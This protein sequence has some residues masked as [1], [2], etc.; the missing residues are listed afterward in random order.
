[1][2]LDCRI[3]MAKNRKQIEM[4]GF[5]DKCATGFVR[6]EDGCIDFTVPS[7][8]AYWR[9]FWDLYTPVSR[10]LNIDNDEMAEINKDDLYF[11]LD[12]ICTTPDYWGKFDTAPTICELIYH[13]DEIRDH[14]MTLF[15][16]GDY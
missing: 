16:E 1:M 11:I 6:D 5:W 4:E 3:I 12:I 8:V 10:R 9:K 2:G 13:Y 14:G 7:E 15:F